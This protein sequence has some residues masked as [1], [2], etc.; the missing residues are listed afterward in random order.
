MLRLLF[1]NLEG[2][3]RLSV[4]TD[5]ID[6][7]MN[8]FVTETPT[9]DTDYFSSL[10][11]DAKPGMTYNIGVFKEL[12]L[13]N[14]LK[15]ISVSEGQ[16]NEDTILVDNKEEWRYTLT[17]DPTSLSFAA[18]GETKSL[19]SV[20]STKQKYINNIA[21]GSPTPVAYTTTVSGTGFSKGSSETQVVAANNT[22]ETTRSGSMVIKQSEGTKQVSVSLSQ[23]AGAVTYEYTLTV[24]PTSLSFAATGE[25]KTVTV[26]S[27]K[28][29]KV[30]G[31]NSGSPTPV[32]Y[33]TTVSG[34]GFSKGSSETQVVA[35]NNTGGQRTGS[36]T[37]SASEGGKKV[38]ITLTQAG[39]SA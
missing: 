29:K 27:T 15:L 13:K 24:D 18:T 19:T 32:A 22:T 9:G 2:D 21:V 6:S 10:G 1:V 36:A 39:A 26:T 11:V 33:T 28:Q 16:N 35:A 30:G 3:K 12:S 5:G 31:A 7:Q 4:I 20:V 17:V 14:Y 25:T 37:V 23:A 8:V 38:D 34:T